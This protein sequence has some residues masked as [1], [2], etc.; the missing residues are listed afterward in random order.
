MAY[1]LRCASCGESFS[2]ASA[3]ALTCS[4]A[5]RNR[6]YRDALIAQRRRLAEQAEQAL[7]S[8]DVAALE[9]VAMT[10]ARILAA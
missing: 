4:V 8:G 6:K 3:A 1:F 5:C 10:A 9:L 7:A 2:A